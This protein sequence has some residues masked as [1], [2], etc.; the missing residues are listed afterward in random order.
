MPNSATAR[1]FSYLLCL[2][3]L[4]L[5]LTGCGGNSNAANGNNGATPGTTNSGGTAAGGSGGSFPGVTNPSTGA[6]YLYAAIYTDAGGV[7]AFSNSGGSLT[8]VSGSP[9][10]QQ[11]SAG[12]GA[13]AATNGYVY[14][15]NL[16]TMTSHT[17][18]IYYRADASSGALTQAGTA[19]AGVDTNGDS[20]NAYSVGQPG[21]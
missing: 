5:A 19:D 7:A 21:S 4:F 11:G 8:A 14:V 20:E 1:Q 9:Y 12:M 17:Q 18:L 13:M 10:I 6:A 3:L 16:P 2:V 15:A